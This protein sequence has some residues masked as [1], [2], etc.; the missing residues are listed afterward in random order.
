[1]SNRRPSNR[2]PG[3]KQFSE[4]VNDFVRKTHRTAD[5]FTRELLILI[6]SRIDQ[7]SPIGDPKHW[8][9]PAPKDYL[10]GTFRGS[11]M[12]GVDDLNTDQPGTRDPNRKMLAVARAMKQIPEKAAGHVYFYA[13]SVPYATPLEYGWSY[14]QAPYGIV[15][16][17][18]SEF[19]SMTLDALKK[20]KADVNS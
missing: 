11:W 6:M 2:V 10:P 12:L 5:V 3:K 9:H 18:I 7:R 20:A 4:Q 1:M 15:A 13:N 8:E 14:R 19:R 17:T 16:A